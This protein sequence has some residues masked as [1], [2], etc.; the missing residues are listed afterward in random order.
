[1]Q[2]QIKKLY[3]EQKRGKRVHSLIKKLWFLLK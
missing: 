1:M 3:E 2:D